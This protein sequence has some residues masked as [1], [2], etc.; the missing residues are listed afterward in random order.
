M[1]II[2]LIGYSGSGKSTVAKILS[3]K[4]GIK[5]LKSTTTRTKRHETDNELYFVNEN[6]FAN[7]IN[8]GQILAYAL[9]NNNH[10]GLTRDEMLKHVDESTVSYVVDYGGY[11]QLKNFFKDVKEVNVISTYMC[12]PLATLVE[13]NLKRGEHGRDVEKEILTHKLASKNYNHIVSTFW[14][15][16]QPLITELEILIE[17]IKLSTSGMEE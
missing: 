5:Q 14:H 6:T 1:D 11:E 2:C 17:N 7:L 9:I 12:C 8:S 13:R 10:Y 15:D 4:F 3:D 16:S